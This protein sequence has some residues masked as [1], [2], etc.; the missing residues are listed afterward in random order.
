MRA[1]LFEARDPPGAAGHHHDLATVRNN[2]ACQNGRVKDDAV[3]FAILRSHADSVR[4]LIA[5]DGL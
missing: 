1:L 4:H 5:R 2:A 3:P